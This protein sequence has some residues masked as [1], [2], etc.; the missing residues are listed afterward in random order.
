MNYVEVLGDTQEALTA[1][2]NE[3]GKRVTRSRVLEDVRKHEHYT[4]PSIARRIKHDKALQTR[5]A[6][7][8]ELKRKRYREKYVI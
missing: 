6:D 4:K 8:R 1:A 2:L 3:F 7:A 5:R